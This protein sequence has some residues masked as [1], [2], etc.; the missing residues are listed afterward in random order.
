MV[1]KPAVAQ[2]PATAQSRLPVVAV[3]AP[4]G[5]ACAGRFAVLCG[6]REVDPTVE[7]PV[8]TGSLTQTPSDCPEAPNGFEATSPD[9]IQD[10]RALVAIWM[11][12]IRTRFLHGEPT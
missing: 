6:D 7:D 5:V 2:L 3:R 11:T 1:A 8:V 4:E 10:M 12:T 9:V